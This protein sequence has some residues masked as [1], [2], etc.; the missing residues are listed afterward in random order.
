MSYANQY[1]LY[2]QLSDSFKATFHDL[3]WG[4]IA[5]HSVQCDLHG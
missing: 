5:P 4:S 3:L 2:P 1:D